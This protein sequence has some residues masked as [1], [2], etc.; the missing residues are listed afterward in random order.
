MPAIGLI[1]NVVLWLSLEPS[2]MLV[3]GVW[4]LIGVGY[5]LWNTRFVRA[6][7][8]ALTGPIEIER[9]EITP[10]A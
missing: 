3:G 9:E 8:P 2:A 10:R 7:P 4:T 1:A 6:E 5:L